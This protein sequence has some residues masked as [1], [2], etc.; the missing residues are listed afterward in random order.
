VGS[1]RKEPPVG[2]DVLQAILVNGGANRFGCVL[3]AGIQEGWP[4][5]RGSR[6]P[7]AGSAKTRRL[8]P[9]QVWQTHVSES[10]GEGLT[11]AVR[12]VEETL[13]TQSMTT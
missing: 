6:S 12:I 1:L 7:C 13:Q 8:P 2:A 5:N 10:I 9:W 11:L 3:M 4:L